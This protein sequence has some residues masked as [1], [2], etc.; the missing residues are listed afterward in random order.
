QSFSGLRP[1]DQA[2]I[3]LEWRGRD[4]PTFHRGPTESRQDAG[5][6][7]SFGIRA[8]PFGMREQPARQVRL[9]TF[10]DGFQAEIAGKDAKIPFGG[11]Q[12]SRIEAARLD[13][14]TQAVEML[15]D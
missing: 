10:A 11:F 3:A 12:T 15:F 13:A 4:K 9:P 5:Q 2:P 7:I 8:F 1:A 6:G 14:E